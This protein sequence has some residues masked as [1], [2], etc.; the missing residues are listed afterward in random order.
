MLHR[1]VHAQYPTR[2]GR[3][4]SIKQIPETPVQGMRQRLCASIQLLNDNYEEEHAE[5]DGVMVP[6]KSTT[7]TAEETA[8]QEAP[9]AAADTDL[10]APMVALIPDCNVHVGDILTL[11]LLHGDENK[12]L[13]LPYQLHQS[14][15]YLWG[16]VTCALT[17]LAAMLVLHFW[18]EGLPVFFAPSNKVQAF[19]QSGWLCQWM[20]GL[21]D[22]ADADQQQMEHELQECCSIIPAVAWS[23]NILLFGHLLALMG[24]SG[25][26][27]WRVRNA[28]EGANGG[29]YQMLSRNEHGHTEPT[30]P[31]SRS[32]GHG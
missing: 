1:N 30:S 15:A 21:D 9:S 14:R 19:F 18:M 17:M 13:H 10:D 3:V 4:V 26:I 8:N 31:D 32:L 12:L 2:Q 7:T 20:V 6:D 23:Y 5:F 24:F 28:I 22:E 16:A 27:W 29:A 25:H 11:S